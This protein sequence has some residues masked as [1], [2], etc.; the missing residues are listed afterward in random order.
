MSDPIVP[1]VLFA[2]ARPAHLTRVLACLRE[3]AVP[4]ILAYADGAT[5]GGDTAAVAETRALMRGID[6]TEVLLLSGRMT[7]CACPAPTPGFVR[8]CVPT[9][10]TRR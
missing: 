6:W 3:N 10:A 9:Q 8:C 2:Y 5:G 1:V 7:S 4:L